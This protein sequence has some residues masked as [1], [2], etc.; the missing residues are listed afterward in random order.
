MDHSGWCPDNAICMDWIER[1][2]LDCLENFIDPESVYM[3]NDVYA[4]FM[5]QMAAV[6]QFRQSHAST[7]IN[8]LR[9][10]TSAGEL[11]IKRVPLL[12]NFCY[13]GTET[14]FQRLE[15]EKV[16]QEFEKAFFGEEYAT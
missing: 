11:T 2:A 9:I 1:R 15:W 4:D 12:S 3:S 16:N 14:S 6:S 5:K 7:G 10:I 8:I 13:V